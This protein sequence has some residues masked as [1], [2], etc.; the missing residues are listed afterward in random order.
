MSISPAGLRLW[1]RRFAGRNDGR[2]VVLMYHRVAEPLSDPWSLSV[3]PGHFAEHLQVLK[4]LTRAFRLR[5]LSQRL[6]EG[7]IPRWSVAVTFDDGYCDN[8][9]SALP[10]LERS[11]VPATVFLA[12]G[13]LGS[14]R[15]Y[16]W[17]ELD[18]LFLQTGQLPSTLRLMLNGT[19]AEWDLGPAA[20]YQDAEFQRHRVWKAEQTPPTVRQ[21]LYRSIWQSLQRMEEGDREKVLTE[22]FQWAG[23]TL[24]ARPGY[25]PMTVEEA[26]ALGKSGLV[27]LG[28]HTTTH[29]VLSTLPAARQRDEIERSK[30]RVQEITGAGVTSFAYPYGD[31]NEESVSI[32]RENGFTGA[33]STVPGVVRKESD[34]LRLPR[35]HVGDW[36][37]DEFERHLSEWFEK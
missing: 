12:T 15:E 23:T 35:V 10:L 16:W 32:V 14:H 17:D 21:E 25:R 30:A 27:E 28:A 34:P 4:K 18:H 6:E 37:G 13:Y 20:L 26:A 24:K 8:F 36:G 22:L 1:L 29:P 3:T 2:A 7:R 19:P 5:E 9:Q 31:F 11:G 33:C